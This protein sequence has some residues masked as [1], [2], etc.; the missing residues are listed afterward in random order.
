MFHTNRYPLFVLLSFLMVTLS[1][2]IMHAKS[3]PLPLEYVRGVQQTLHDIGYWPGAID[4][5][6]GS[7]TQSAI[8]QYQRDENL[9][10]TGRLDAATARRVEEA[11]RMRDSDMAKFRGMD[12]NNDGAITRREYSGNDR[13]F[14][15]HDWN[16]DGVLS[17]EEVKPGVHKP[18]RD[19]KG[20]SS[21]GGGSK[22]DGKE[23]GAAAKKP[24]KK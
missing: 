24:P 2:G 1:A 11:R 8:R 20:E 5:V 10:V 14:A 18:A 16:G 21:A 17:G 12:A 19:A 15:N 22:N 3:A 7:Q 13:A 23:R 4:G 6:L 9:P